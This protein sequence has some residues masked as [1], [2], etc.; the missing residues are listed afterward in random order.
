MTDFGHDLLFGSFVQ[1]VA[2]PAQHAVELAVRSE[3]AG[4]DLVT[5][6]DHPYQTA[7]LDTWTLMA[8]AAA[9]TS[10][11]RLSGNVLN[12]PLRD[13]AMLA[14]GAAGLDLLS[15]GRV[16]M[17]LGAGAYWDAIEAMGGPRRAPG[18]ALRALE[19]A[20]RIMRDIWAAGDR[21]GVRVDGEF[22]RV[23]GAKRG[24]APAHPIG[25]W[26]G[27]YRPRMLRLVGR[28]ADGWLPTLRAFPDGPSQLADANEHLEEG[29]EAAGRD[30]GSIRRLLNIGGHFGDA[31]GDLLTGP[32]EQ[33]AE[34]LADL[35]LSY[36][37]SGF[38]LMT[39]DPRDI[40][41][42]GHDVAPAVRELV[43]AE[44]KG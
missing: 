18:Q 26:I 31:A 2:Q 30:P 21:G 37:I 38:I 39:D 16:E 13:P 19:E 3:A 15:G 17:G 10:R 43:A 6:Q 24:P 27:G 11:I 4:L 14:R 5:F 7:Y 32:P 34:E 33:W 12:L 41:T 35:A 42:F 8:F 36:G 25:V 40:D 20:V 44:R 9:R 23:H 1:P 29:A 28:I 22:Y